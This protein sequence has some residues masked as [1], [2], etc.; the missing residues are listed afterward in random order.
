MTWHLSDIGLCL[1]ADDVPIPAGPAD[2]MM[3]EMLKEVPG[4]M[5]DGPE[6]SVIYQLLQF[7]P[8]D[9]VHYSASE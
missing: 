1:N 8:M 9:V 4:R 5:P 7:R 2:P 3:T 6:E